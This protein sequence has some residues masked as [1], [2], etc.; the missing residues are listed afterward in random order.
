MNG[1]P[2]RK[3]RSKKVIVS[4][5]LGTVLLIV[6]F[7][8]LIITSLQHPAAADNPPQTQP[9]TAPATSELSGQSAPVVPLPP[10]VDPFASPQPAGPPFTVYFTDPYSPTAKDHTGGPDEI[11]A[12]A[13]DR[14]QYSVDMAIYNLSL[15][16]I[17]DALIHASQR[18]VNVRMVM[19]SESMDSETVKTLEA[20]KIPIIGD[21]RQGLMHNKFTIIDNQE[22]WTGSLNLTTSGT[23]SDHNNLVRIVNPQAAQD[24]TTEFEEMFTED[25]FGVK[26][27][28]DTPF[29]KIIIDGTLL[30]IYFSPD[31]NVAAPFINLLSTARKSIDILAYS[32]T[33]NDMAQIILARAKDGVVVRGVFDVSQEK[34]NKGGEYDRFKKAGFDVRLNTN[35]GL[36]HNKVIIVDGQAVAFGSYNF[37]KSAEDNNDENMV[38]I[39]NPQV[40]QQYLAEFERIFV[41]SKK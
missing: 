16:N 3:P 5:A 23:Y 24:Y 8:Y 6:I 36:M 31:D 26:G 11:L 39:H 37:S 10:T 17:R 15:P 38:I 27:N 20:N 41:R 29:P 33:R 1:T 40:A 2:T 7:I 14:A 34:N 4:G 32:F 12:A 35:N 22:V 18:G 9:Q 19:E 30:E 21:R 13:I 25:K 28:K